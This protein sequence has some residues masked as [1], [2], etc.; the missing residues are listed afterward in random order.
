ME[1]MCVD[2]ELCGGLTRG[3]T[4]ADRRRTAEARRNADVCLAVDGE[5]FSRRFVEALKGFAR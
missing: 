5:R 1:R 3:A 2:I 4:I